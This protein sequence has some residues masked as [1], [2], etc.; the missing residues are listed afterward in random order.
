MTVLI[1]RRLV[2]E[3][4]AAVARAWSIVHAG[5]D[6]PRDNACKLLEWLELFKVDPSTEL[7]GSLHLAAAGEEKPSCVSRTERG[8]IMTW[9]SRDGFAFARD[10][11]GELFFFPETDLRE[12]RHLFSGLLGEEISR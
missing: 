9:Y 6:G 1:E 3:V 5:T 12:K 11:N 2:N 4:A 10:H 8:T 7:Y